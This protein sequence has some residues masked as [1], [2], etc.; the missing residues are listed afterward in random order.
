MIRGNQP[1][2]RVSDIRVLEADQAADA[3]AKAEIEERMAA[4]QKRL[5]AMQYLLDT[6]DLPGSARQPERTPA[7]P[8]PKKIVRARPEP[9][10]AAPK[11]TPF[12]ANGKHLTWPIG[13]ERVLSQQT[14]GISYKDLLAQL[15]KT[16]LGQNVSEGA[17]GFYNAIARM[18]E[19]GA[20]VKAGGL[21][22]SAALAKKINAS[23]EPLPVRIVDRGGSTSIVLSI[24]KEHPE[25]LT[26]PEIKEIVSKHPDSPASILKHKHYV[27]NVLSVLAERRQITR[28]DGKYRLAKTQ[29]A[30]GVH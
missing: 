30:A 11:S 13:I 7:K 22:Y 27:Y 29:M 14:E 25:G 28:E 6:S 17:K 3:R 19:A 1:I 23:G 9:K 16:E 4:R 12:R 8:K 10:S 2:A 24:L 5:D 15:T 21:L 20:V 26:A 18:S